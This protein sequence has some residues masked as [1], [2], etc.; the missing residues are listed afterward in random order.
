MTGATNAS[1]RRILL[2]ILL[3]A[4]LLAAGLLFIASP[5]LAGLEAAIAR[6]GAL[7]TAHPW[8]VAAGFVVAQALLTGANLPATAITLLA[9]GALFGTGT[10]ILLCSLGTTGGALIALFWSRYLFRSWAERRFASFLDRV[11]HGLET[12]GHYFLFAARMI[13]VIPF[14]VINPVMGL[15]RYPVLP[16]CLVTLLGML[17]VVSVYVNAGAR[18]AEVR[19]LDD[20]MSPLLLL[21]LAAVGVVPLLLHLGVRAL[22]GRHQAG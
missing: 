18:L 16:Y 10:G 2:L 14:W 15:T 22:R 5:D 20:V 9:G 21:S 7:Q 6:M 17:P 4:G 11:N 19:S 13:P 12:E 8:Q 1:R 3:C